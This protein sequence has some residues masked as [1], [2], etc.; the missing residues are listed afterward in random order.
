MRY[1]IAQNVLLMEEQACD[2]STTKGLMCR[3]G[4]LSGPVPPLPSTS[5]LA[6]AR[7]IF[8]RRGFLF[9]QKKLQIGGYEKV[10]LA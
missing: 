6:S 8:T 10:E 3:V 1:G 5:S 4:A 2:W 9:A 7:G